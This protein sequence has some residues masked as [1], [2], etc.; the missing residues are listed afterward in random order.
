MN[1][2]DP[3]SPYPRIN[4]HIQPHRLPALD[5]DGL[6]QVFAAADA[7]SPHQIHHV[8][9][10][11]QGDAVSAVSRQTKPGDL[12]VALGISHGETTSRAY[13]RRGGWGLIHFASNNLGQPAVLL[14]KP[15]S[16]L[17]GAFQASLD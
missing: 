17:D 4:A 9:A 1:S 12:L 10:G 16:K 13:L 8:R 15:L 14:D 5:L 3:A 11:L 7:L 6:G 2:P